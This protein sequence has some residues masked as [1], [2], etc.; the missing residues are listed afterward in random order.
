[1]QRLFLFVPSGYDT[2][3]LVRSDDFRLFRNLNDPKLI[4]PNDQQSSKY[5]LKAGKA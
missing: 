3:L 1:M 5:R 2:M 4:S